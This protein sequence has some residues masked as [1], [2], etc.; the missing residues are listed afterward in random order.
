MAACLKQTVSQEKST[1]SWT[2]P[3]LRRKNIGGE[4]ISTS[5]RLGGHN[6]KVVPCP[7][8]CLPEMMNSKV[9]GLQFVRNQCPGQPWTLRID[10]VGRPVKRP[11]VIPDW[12]CLS[13]WGKSWSTIR[14]N[15]NDGHET[16]DLIVV[17]PSGSIFKPTWGLWPWRSICWK[18]MACEAF[19]N[20]VDLNE[21]GGWQHIPMDPAPR[22]KKG[23]QLALVFFR[24]GATNIKCVINKCKP[25]FN[26]LCCTWKGQTQMPMQMPCHRS[27]CCA[28]K[29][30]IA[31][32]NNAAIASQDLSYTIEPTRS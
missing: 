3:L 7:W 29:E 17:N 28:T 23:C 6:L 27:P 32:K 21:N 12:A 22:W 24:A 20:S 25:S 9:C 8:I 15:I 16:G 14:I 30:S 2:Q 26:H 18:K 19:P 31:L 5:W 4:D 1:V 11:H 10:E 13:K